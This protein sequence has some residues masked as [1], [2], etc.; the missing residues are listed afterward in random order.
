MYAAQLA[1]PDGELAATFGR[2]TLL[3]YAALV[4][5]PGGGA[6]KRRRLGQASVKAAA[7]A[8]AVRPEE[9]DQGH[10][11][12]G[13]PPPRGRTAT[14][15]S[16]P[17]TPTRGGFVVCDGHGPAD[18]VHAVASSC[19]VPLVW[20]PVTIDGHR[21]IDGGA[22]SSANA[23][24]ADGH[25]R[26]VVLA[27]LPRS[28]SRHHALPAQLAR[29]GAKATAVVSPDAASLAAIGRNV[30]DPANRPAS[31]RAGHAQAAHVLDEVRTAWSGASRGIR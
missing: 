6:T 19:A 30:L 3:R 20:P 5:A 2:L 16:P 25:D 23:D 11:A 21:Y 17:W 14:C 31:A 24:L 27:P 28:L 9:R 10:P 26:V 12:T 29:T 22:R 18:L 1:D 8:H 13:S 15:G 7:K 4:L